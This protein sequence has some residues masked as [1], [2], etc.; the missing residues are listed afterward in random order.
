VGASASQ[1][2]REEGADW[3]VMGTGIGQQEWLVIGAW[4]KTGSFKS[5]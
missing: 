1:V 5:W 3:L 2:L 4:T